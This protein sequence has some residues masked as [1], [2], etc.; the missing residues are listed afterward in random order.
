M[1]SLLYNIH[2]IQNLSPHLDS[3]WWVPYFHNFA[4]SRCLYE[5]HSVPFSKGEQDVVVMVMALQSPVFSDPKNRRET[6]IYG[7]NTLKTGESNLLL[8]PVLR[9]ISGSPVFR[10]AGHFSTLA[11]W[12]S[13]LT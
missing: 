10:D 1:N 2:T 12:V 4:F 3:Y 8:S 5:L 7:K 13:V 11:F 6:W 9:F